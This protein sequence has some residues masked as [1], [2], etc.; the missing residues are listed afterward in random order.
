[1][2]G[3]KRISELPVTTALSGNDR[4][5]VLTNPASSAQTQT[6]TLTSLSN[7]LRY[8]NTSVSGVIKVGNNLSVNATGFLNVQTNNLTANSLAS[9]NSLVVL[10]PNSSG[11]G[12]GF[13]TIQLIPETGYADQ[14]IIIDPT[15]PNHIH[16]RAGGAQDNS[17]ASLYFGGENSYFNVGSGSNPS[18]YISSNSN[19]WTFNTNGVITFPDST[20][21]NTAFQFTANS[22]NWSGSAPTTLNEA[23]NRL[24]ILLKTLNG[25]TGA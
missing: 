14:K 3:S 15:T 10:V 2:S 19:Q 13:S 4:V 12:Y 7:N 16:I 17:N 5:V 1:M 21:Q 25:G 8:A 6:I 22:S 9:G 23:V 24:A 11:D 20:T 18:V